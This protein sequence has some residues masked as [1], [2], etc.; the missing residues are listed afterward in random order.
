MLLN[1]ASALAASV[2]KLPLLPLIEVPLIA[3]NVTVLPVA[4]PREVRVGMS[5]VTSLSV[6]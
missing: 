6:K 4:R 1:A 2:V 3:P 5:A